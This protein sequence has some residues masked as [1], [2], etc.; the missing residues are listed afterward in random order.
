MKKILFLITVILILSVLFVLSGC[1]EGE[2]ADTSADT[3]DTGEDASDFAPTVFFFSDALLGSDTGGETEK[4]S[5]DM[6]PEAMSESGDMADYFNLKTFAQY[7]HD[8]EKKQKIIVAGEK[9][10]VEY[11]RSEKIVSDEVQGIYDS[12]DIYIDDEI[13]TYHVRSDGEVVH[14]HK[15]I[16]DLVE[17]EISEEDARKIAD[18]YIA[19]LLGERADKYEFY[20]VQYHTGYCLVIYQLKM[21]GVDNLD[22]V[23]V[24]IN[25]DHE[26][27]SFSAQNLGR[28]DD[29]A[30]SFTSTVENKY[31]T[32]LKEKL[33]GLGIEGYELA[34][35][36]L[37]EYADQLYLCVKMKQGNVTVDGA[38]KFVDQTYFYISVDSEEK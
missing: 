18:D 34:D 1:N 17:V 9:K 2:I 26:V 16:P 6:F 7:T 36:Y 19:K 25:S 23:L 14:M 4:L 28:F 24:F 33:A 31:I 10:S 13:T 35:S 20:S 37:C 3:T 22:R 27:Y 8:E 29:V 11:V 21:D 30:D 15:G 5:L 32:H 12:Y 38:E